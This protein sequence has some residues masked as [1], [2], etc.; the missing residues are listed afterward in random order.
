MKKYIIWIMIFVC[1]L[2]GC[3]NGQNNNENK[4]TE[5]RTEVTETETENSEQKATIEITVRSSED[6]SEDRA[7][8]KFCVLENEMATNYVGCIDK[9]GNIVFRYLEEDVIKY[10]KFERGSAYIQFTNGTRQIVDKDGVAMCSFTEEEL[11]KFYFSGDGY[12]YFS[13]ENSGFDTMGII[14]TIIDSTGNVIYQS[15]QGFLSYCG[16]DVFVTCNFTTGVYKFYNIKEDVY[17][18]IDNIVGV[19]PLSPKISFSNGCSMLKT[20]DGYIWVSDLGEISIFANKETLSAYNVIV[21]EIQE[22]LLMYGVTEAGGLGSYG[23]QIDQLIVYNLEDDTHVNILNTPA[24]QYVDN[25]YEKFIPKENMCFSNDRI[26]IPMIGADFEMYIAIFDKQWNEILGPTKIEGAYSYKYNCNR[27]VIN[28]GN[29]DIVM[30]ENGQILFSANDIGCAS[31]RDYSD[32]VALI[33]NGKYID[34]MGNL[35]FTEIHQNK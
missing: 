31:I 32:D 28:F 24:E 1:V 25:M 19:D 33:G 14:A 23:K 5:L 26:V 13:R 6:F 22:G 17:F 2:T 20:K 10:T 30:D 4:E 35:L 29:G 7:W 16:N 27:L 8:V 3:N 11:G 15:E 18:E 9:S 34:K 12:Y 21:G